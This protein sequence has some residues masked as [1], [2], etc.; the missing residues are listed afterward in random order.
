M[1]TLKGPSNDPNFMKGIDITNF[2]LFILLYQKKETLLL[3]FNSWFNALIVIPK[4]LYFAAHLWFF[5]IVKHSIK[6]HFT[7]FYQISRL[8]YRSF[9]PPILGG[10][11]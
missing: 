7:T 2:L 6:C 11:A 1:T 8:N 10:V 5:I 4:M 3:I 9:V